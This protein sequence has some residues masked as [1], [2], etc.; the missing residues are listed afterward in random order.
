MFVAAQRQISLHRRAQRI[1]VA[2]GVT[3]GEI[4][5]SVCQRIVVLVVQVL[6]AEI[7][8]SFARP[9]L[10]GEKQ[11]LRH[12]VRLVPG[13]GLIGPGPPALTVLNRHLGKVRQRGVGGMLQNR[14][15]IPVAGKLV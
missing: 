15:R 2:V 5:L 3:P 1:D 9:A 12:G 14:K 11:V 13:I 4:T 8:I 7:A 10:V 6:N